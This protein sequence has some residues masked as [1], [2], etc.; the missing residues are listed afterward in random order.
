ME[1]FGVSA[2]VVQCCEK[3]LPEWD[4]V[5]YTAI[6][7][8][9]PPQSSIGFGETP[10]TAAEEPQPELVISLETTSDSPLQQPQQP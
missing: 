3:E 10:C 9:E 7:S 5:N 2:D 4:L 1:C 6:T 8:E